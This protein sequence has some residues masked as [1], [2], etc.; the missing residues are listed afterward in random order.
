LQVLWADRDGDYPV[1]P[2]DP[3]WMLRQPLLAE[4]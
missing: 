4:I 3:S 2:G 1:R